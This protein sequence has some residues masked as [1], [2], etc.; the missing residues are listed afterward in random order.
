ML[1]FDLQ[2]TE[3][4]WQYYVEK[5]DKAS[6]GMKNG[7]YWPSG[8]TL[9]GSSS[10]NAMT[11]VRGSK[12][13]YD[14]W[15][16]MGNPTWDY[17]N[18]LKYFK[19][20]EG[21]K[22]QWITDED[23]GKY[24][25]TDGPLPITS[26]RDS[27]PIKS[28]IYGA[29]K[30]LKYAEII[31][32]NANATLGFTY[33]FGTIE[34]GKRTS[35]AKAFL[36]AAKDRPNLTVIKNA[37]VTKI[38]INSKGEAEAVNFSV[39]GKDIIAK[40]GK[41]IIL[42]AGAVSTPKILMLSGIGPEEHLNELGIEVTKNLPVGKNLEDHLMVP[43][44]LS[45]HKSIAQ[46]ASDKE[47][48]DM[49]YMYMRYNIG[50]Y[51][52]IGATDFTGFVNTLNNTEGE[53][54]DIQ[55]TFFYF[56]KGSP[57]L[58]KTLQTIG[59]ND[60]ISDSITKAGEETNILISDIVLLNPK[61]SGKIELRSNDPF[62][63]PKV[64][65]NYLNEQEDLDTVLRGIRLKQKFLA[66]DSYKQNEAEEVRVNIPG[67]TE[68][69][70]DSDE[71]WYCYIRHMSSTMYNPTGTAKM[72]PISDK[73]S[74]VDSRLRVKGIKG[75]RVADASIMPKIVSGN[76]N[77]PTIMIGEKAADFIKEDW[78]DSVKHTEL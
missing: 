42:S 51:G 61:S 43:Y 30:E 6:I 44:I 22:E 49:L 62:D 14:Q 31:D 10:I 9:G 24:H 34:N 77:A 2:K 37:F 21:N 78:A 40:A 58:L 26:F 18:V 64:F 28:V 53:S 12:R 50:A 65:A 46:V 25:G 5:S 15:E 41:E 16:E 32:I 20:S 56:N 3:Y 47:N 55:Y 68:L 72:G 8:K 70:Y 33:V 74:V 76:A 4:D 59:Y 54:P 38:V 66:T 67:C 7:C 11:Y 52:T 19:K 69:E 39:S 1:W 71:Y 48:M 27:T 45:F 60:E 17:E 36:F 23:E 75:L 57:S 13:D 29:A 35:A 73:S 63:K